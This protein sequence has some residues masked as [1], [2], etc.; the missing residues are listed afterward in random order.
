MLSKN[1]DKVAVRSIL[2]SLSGV[3][4]LTIRIGV[5]AAPQN[6]CFL[7]LQRRLTY[8]R[9]CFPDSKITAW[10]ISKN[11]KTYFFLPKFTDFVLLSIDF[12]CQ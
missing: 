11:V 5:R 4:I 2:N 7:I 1:Q 10:L 12:F 9:S 8:W 6:P 3:A